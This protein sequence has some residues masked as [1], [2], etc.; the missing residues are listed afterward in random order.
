MTDFFAM[1][2]YAAYVWSAYGITLVVLLISIWTARK[3]RLDAIER[4]RRSKVHE[5][6]RSKPTVRQVPE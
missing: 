2:G 1:D 4:A 5:Q 3:R 6:P